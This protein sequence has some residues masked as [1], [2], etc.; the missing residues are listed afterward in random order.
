MAS[1]L[2]PLCVS[3]ARYSRDHARRNAAICGKDT[4]PD[5]NCFIWRFLKRNMT[6]TRGP[7]AVLFRSSSFSG[8]S[9]CSD[10]LAR[11]KTESCSRHLVPLQSSVANLL[12]PTSAALW[13]PACGNIR[14]KVSCPLGKRTICS[15]CYGGALAR[16]HTKDNELA[17]VLKINPGRSA[18]RVRLPSP[19]APKAFGAVTPE[20]RQGGLCVAQFVPELSHSLQS[21]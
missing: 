10:N 15:P 14:F 9:R 12:G 5:R 8:N 16:S 17:R 11:A 4:V 2:V 1:P 13:A 18:K 6:R 7:H 20:Q 3:C 19:P 21:C